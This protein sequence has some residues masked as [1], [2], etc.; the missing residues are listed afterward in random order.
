MKACEEFVHARRMSVPTLGDDFF[1]QVKKIETQASKVRWYYCVIVN[2]GALNY[3]DVIPQV[4]NHCW[5]NVCEPLSQA[6]RFK[7]AQ[8]MREALIKACGIMGPAK[9]SQ[10]SGYVLTKADLL[11][12]DW[13]GD[14]NFGK[15]YTS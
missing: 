10:K 8:K 9:V 15:V 13:S 14:S 6:E 4:W 12:L 11:G 2:L 3:P 1:E 7:V 5:R